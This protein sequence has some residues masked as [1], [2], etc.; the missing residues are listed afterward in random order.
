MALW[1][2]IYTWR[3]QMPILSS[4]RTW[5]ER[6]RRAETVSFSSAA[7]TFVN[8]MTFN[9]VANGNLWQLV[10]NQVFSGTQIQITLDQLATL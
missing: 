9:V 5:R 10:G 4:M 7:D 8:D 3:Q 2:A 1:R 6:G